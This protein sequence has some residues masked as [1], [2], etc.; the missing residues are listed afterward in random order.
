MRNLV[1]GLVATAAIGCTGGG[2]TVGSISTSWSLKTVNGSSIPTCPP[3]FTTAEVHSTQL[4]ANNRPIAGTEKLDLFNC[5]DFAGRISRAPAVYEVFIRIATDNGSGTYATSLKKAVDIVTVDGSYNDTFFDDGGRFLLD[6]QLKGAVSNSTLTCA[7][8]GAKS[9]G[10]TA[11][12]SGGTAATDDV[13][14]CDEPFGVTR[15]ILAGSYTVSVAALDTADAAVGVAPAQTNKTVA[16]PGGITDLGTVI[17][18][19]DN[20]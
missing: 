1:Y 9:A 7:Q 18:P 2:G 11:T 17:I 3:T 14:R 10:I 13:F 4:D 5:D 12:V 8:A 6:W 15:G 19:I 16:R 20:K